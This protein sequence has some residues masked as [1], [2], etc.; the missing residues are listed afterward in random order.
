VKLTWQT[1]EMVN[2]LHAAEAWLRSPANMDAALAGALT[3]PVTALLQT[4]LEQGVAPDAFWAH[5]VPPS[6]SA[7]SAPGG[8]RIVRCV[9]PG[10]PRYKPWTDCFLD[11]EG[12]ECRGSW[13]QALVRRII[14]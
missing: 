11:C 4:L 9:R 13:R 3:A 2:C 1:S 12:V 5:V 10:R 7:F 6:A 8:T 14:K